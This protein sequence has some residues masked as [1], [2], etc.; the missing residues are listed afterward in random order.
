MTQ[1]AFYRIRRALARRF[2]VEKRVL[3]PRSRIRDVMKARAEEWRAVGAE[4]GAWEWPQ[5]RSERRMFAFAGGVR[6]LGEVAHHLTIYDAQRLRGAGRGWTRA[7]IADQ[8]VRIIERETG[9][10]MSRYP[11]SAHFVRDLGLISGN[12]C[13][14]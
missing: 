9:V 3:T 1:R 5:L 12:D 6:T 4:T 11:L 2:E 13:S 10:D 8:V 14:A 7:E